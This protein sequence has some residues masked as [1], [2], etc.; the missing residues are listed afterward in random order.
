MARNRHNQN[1]SQHSPISSRPNLTLEE[2]LE[3]LERVVIELEERTTS[4]GY[5]PTTPSGDGS[6]IA[7]LDKAYHIIT[8]VVILVL[9][10]SK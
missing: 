5:P 4:V 10:F 3:A 6:I 2:R 1:A 9:F 7:F 8:F